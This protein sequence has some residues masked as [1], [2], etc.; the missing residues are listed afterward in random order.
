V[1]VGSIE[2][3]EK[4]NEYARETEISITNKFATIG[5]KVVVCQWAIDPVIVQL[6]HSKGRSL[7][8][9]ICRSNE[10]IEAYLLSGILAI[11]WVKSDDIE[12]I[13]IATGATICSSIDQLASSKLGQSKSVTLHLIVDVLTKKGAS[14]IMGRVWLGARDH[15]RPR[16]RDFHYC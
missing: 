1:S 14:N 2:E 3:F 13:A 8:I 16:R 6:L 4:L 10:V 5:A 11:K 7:S 15:S 9:H 12:R